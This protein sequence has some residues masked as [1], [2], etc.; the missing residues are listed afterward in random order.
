[1]PP[2]IV[3]LEAAHL[4]FVIRWCAFGEPFEFVA[5]AVSGD[6]IADRAGRTT[7]RS[8]IPAPL[9]FGE[10][11]CRVLDR[12]GQFDPLALAVG[13]SSGIT[14]IVGMGISRFF[15]GPSRPR[16]RQ[17]PQRSNHVS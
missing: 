14:I 3:R 17:Q 9:D 2:S 8:R 10:K 12:I 15:G 7:G 6:E 11:P 1:M 4:H 5:C 13:V 16:Q